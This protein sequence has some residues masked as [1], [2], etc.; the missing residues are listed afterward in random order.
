[1]GPLHSASLKEGAWAFPEYPHPRGR[2]GIRHPVL[3]SPD[4][5]VFLSRSHWD[6]TSSWDLYVGN[7]WAHLDLTTLSLETVS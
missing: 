5:T 3:L 6:S 2:V 1:M 4:A 7:G